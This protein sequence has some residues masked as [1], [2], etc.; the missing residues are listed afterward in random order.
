MEGNDSSES[1]CSSVPVYQRYEVSVKAFLLNGISHRSECE[2]KPLKE[3]R[4][5][6]EIKTDIS[7]SLTPE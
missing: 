3:L 6:K 5:E 4:V 1:E 7:R 2:V